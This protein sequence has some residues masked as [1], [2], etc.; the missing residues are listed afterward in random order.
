[1]RKSAC[2]LY[3]IKHSGLSYCNHFL[4]IP[5]ARTR[6]GQADL[7]YGNKLRKL[8]RVTPQELFRAG[9][10]KIYNRTGMR[11]CNSIPCR[12]LLE[13]NGAILA[14]NVDF[15]A[16]AIAHSSSEFSG[17][18]PFAPTPGNCGHVHSM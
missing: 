15:Q 9:P 1:M 14:F 12:R 7:P 11:G 5:A 3:A 17:A 2:E 4:Y 16:T 18:V 6:N 8:R 13:I 10:A